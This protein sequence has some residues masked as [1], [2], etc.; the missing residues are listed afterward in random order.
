MEGR[1]FVPEPGAFWG[2]APATKYCCA[3]CSGSLEPAPR[4][5]KPRNEKLIGG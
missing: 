2:C 3:P 5:N 4:W 1:L